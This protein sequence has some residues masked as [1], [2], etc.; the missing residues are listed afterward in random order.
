M[1]E[2]MEQ[3]F[4]RLKDYFYSLSDSD[5]LQKETKPFYLEAGST[6]AKWL[7]ETTTHIFH[8]R[9][10]MFNYMKQLGYEISMPDLY[11]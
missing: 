4:G 5:F 11:V 7:V 10:Q 9:A 6:Q 8:H 1:A 3:G 2:A